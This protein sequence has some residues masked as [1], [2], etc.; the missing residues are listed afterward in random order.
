MQKLYKTLDKIGRIDDN[1]VSVFTRF[2][3]DLGSIRQELRKLVN[4]LKEI[5]QDGNS[6]DSS[7]I[8]S[9]T[10]NSLRDIT[11]GQPRPRHRRR[12]HDICH[13]EDDATEILSQHL[14]E[15]A[16]I[17]PPSEPDLAPHWK[18]VFSDWHRIEDLYVGRAENLV[19]S[20]ALHQAKKCAA[21][22]KATQE[23]ASGLAEMAEERHVMWEEWWEVW[24]GWNKEKKRREREDEEEY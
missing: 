16:L 21:V 12:S 14:T 19:F 8:S 22:A 9:G 3:E 17:T 24:E 13:N 10:A 1:Y 18:H 11:N 5:V 15:T 7:K 2:A 4:L 20:E 23:L 6:L